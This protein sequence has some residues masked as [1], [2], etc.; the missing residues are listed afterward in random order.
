MVQRKGGEEKGRCRGRVREKERGRGKGR[1]REK[2]V[3]GRGRDLFERCV[4]EEID[5]VVLLENSL[6]APKRVPGIQV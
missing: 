4:E 5:A 1:G 2:G 3:E 6:Q